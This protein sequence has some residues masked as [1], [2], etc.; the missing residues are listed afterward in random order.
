MHDVYAVWENTLESGRRGLSKQE[1]AGCGRGA[2][3][4][5]GVGLAVGDEVVV[6]VF[7]TVVIVAQDALVRWR[8]KIGLL[9]CV[10]VRTCFSG[11]G[12]SVC[13][14]ERLGEGRTVLRVHHPWGGA[15][16]RGAL[17]DADPTG[18]HQA[19]Q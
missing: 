17:E 18:L 9:A 2:G 12:G 8:R 3:A 5:V 10:Y 6:A 15:G 14:G 1:V 7:V 13:R 4:G 19:G 11:E 16:D